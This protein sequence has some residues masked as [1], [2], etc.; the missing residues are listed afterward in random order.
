MAGKRLGKGL[1]ALIGG[2]DLEKSLES[3]S[4]I[5]SDKIGSNLLDLSLEEIFPNP[6]QP[7]QVFDEEKITELSESIKTVGLIEPIVVTSQKGK[8][9]LIAGE[10]RWRAAKLAGFKTIPA[11]LKTDKKDKVL[12]MMLIENI[13]REDLSAIE[14]ANSYQI[15]LDRKNITQEQL[16]TTIGKSRT[17]ITNL[18]RILKLSPEVQEAINIKEIS[19]G[20][21]KVMVGLKK[22]EQKDILNK[23]TKQDLSVRDVEKIIKTKN[24]A[25]ESS[26]KSNLKK[27]PHIRD[28]EDKL[29]DVFK[30]KV[31]VKEGKD[32]SGKIEIEYYSLDDLEEILK[33]MRIK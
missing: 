12:E 27:D 10:R 21:A 33:K 15:I 31:S 3:S 6:D 29:R 25:G 5:S 28:L 18:L 19:V 22:N 1:S 13:Q 2:G 14:E 17:Y 24:E 23:I 7:R 16:A 26:E 4:K 30:T 8:Y 32:N 11:V 20:H 9:Y